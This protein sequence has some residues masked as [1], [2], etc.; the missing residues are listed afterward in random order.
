MKTELRSTA[1]PLLVV[2]VY[3]AFLGA[4]IMLAVKQ[5]QAASAAW[6]LPLGLIMGAVMN[7]LAPI[8][9]SEAGV[10]V[11]RLPAV[12]ALALVPGVGLRWLTSGTADET[13]YVVVL[14]TSSVFFPLLLH[15]AARARASIRSGDRDGSAAGAAQGPAETQPGEL[16]PGRFL[17]IVA[18]AA[19]L[20]GWCLWIVLDSPRRTEGVAWGAALA[21]F[22]AALVNLVFAPPWWREPEDRRAKNLLA[23]GIVLGLGLG[24]LALRLTPSIADE[25]AFALLLWPS[26]WFFAAILYGASER[27]AS[28]VS[29][30]S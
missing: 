11:L 17:N 18:T 3:S 2:A 8:G 4:S 29:A 15:F 20:F 26:Y 22:V 1:G 10:R 24:V 16:T 23:L 6:A 25:A 12:F 21:F 7:V 5:S 28:T 14:G 9:A 27:R 13:V 19:V 30:P